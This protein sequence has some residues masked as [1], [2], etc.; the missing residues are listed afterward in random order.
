MF[1]F[2][3]SIITLETIIIIIIKNKETTGFLLTQLQI[4]ICLQFIA[5]T[6]LLVGSESMSKLQTKPPLGVGFRHWPLIIQT[7]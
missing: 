7:A 3:S 5:G 6:Q 2:Y 1:S 4:Y